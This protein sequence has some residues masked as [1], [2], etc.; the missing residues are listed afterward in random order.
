[1]PA[2]LG[3]QALPVGG[4]RVAGCWRGGHGAGPAGQDQSGAIAGGDGVGQ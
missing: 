1:M 4:G 3:R 2:S